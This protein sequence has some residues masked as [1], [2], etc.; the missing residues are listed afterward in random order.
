MSLAITNVRILQEFGII[1]G[2]GIVTL[3]IVTITV[4]PILLFYIKLP[5]KKDI[6]RLIFKKESSF[7][8]KLSLI[9]KRYPKYIIL[10]SSFIFCF[11]IY[12]L[13]RI[14]SHVTILGDLNP[15]NKLYEDINFV[16][17]N[18]GGTLPLEIVI[19][20]NTQLK[21]SIIE[22]NSQFYNKINHFSNQLFKNSHI[23]TVTGYWDLEGNLNRN[24]NKYTN[25]QRSEV[26]ISCGIENID[27]EEMDIL[28]NAIKEE[29]LKLDLKNTF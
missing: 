12:G 6:N 7:S 14:D 8:F 22:P 5:S 13:S 19:Q 11:S 29:Y 24:A 27:S 23:K 2:V 20:T 3:F 15:G 18:F 26:R 16:E 9:V 4:M 1:M 10:F 17:D 25:K 28:K 21:N